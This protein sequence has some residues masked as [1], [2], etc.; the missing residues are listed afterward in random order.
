MCLLFETLLFNAAAAVHIGC[1]GWCEYTYTYELISRACAHCKLCGVCTGH[2]CA[3]V[4]LAT[5]AGVLLTL[6]RRSCSSPAQNADMAA[7]MESVTRTAAAAWSGG[8]SEPGIPTNAASLA[9]WLCCTLNHDPL[10]TIRC[11]WDLGVLGLAG[12][13]CLCVMFKVVVKSQGTVHSHTFYVCIPHAA[14]APRST[15]MCPILQLGT[16]A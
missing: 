4:F 16:A 5:C 7:G 8:G 10:L 2:P 12:Q 15:S 14:C 13:N 6:L 1:S 9:G 11:E 3:R